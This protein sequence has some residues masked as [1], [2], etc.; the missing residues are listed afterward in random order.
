MYALMNDV[1]IGDITPP[2]LSFDSCMLIFPIFS[3]LS[4]YLNTYQLTCAYILGCQ[5]L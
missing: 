4:R 3:W 2:I 5:I 1:A